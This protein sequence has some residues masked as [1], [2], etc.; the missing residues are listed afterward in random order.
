M[1]GTL[2][3]LSPPLWFVLYNDLH[4]YLSRIEITHP[5]DLCLDDLKSQQIGHLHKERVGTIH[6][7]MLDYFPRENRRIFFLSHA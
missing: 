2:T 5:L 4:A 6:Q 7:H 3:S 1:V